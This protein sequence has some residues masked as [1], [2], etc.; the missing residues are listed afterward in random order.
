[1]P[2]EARKKELLK[3]IEDGEK[4]VAALYQQLTDY[5]KANLLEFFNKPKGEPDFGMPANPLQLELLEA[6]ENPIY[7][8]F[9]FTGANRIGK[10][11]WVDDPVLTPVG[12][13]RIGDIKVGDIVYS[14]DGT[15]TT[16]TGVFPQGV[17]NCYRFIFDD[18]CS[19]IVGKKHLWK[20]LPYTA[21][22]AGRKSTG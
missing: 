20:V 9:T 2:S 13:V 19:L 3:I 11:Q 21:R 1:M 22:I 7:K 17:R 8:V 12:F 5:R 16:V 15:P 18:E 10:D 6:W 4:K 14:K